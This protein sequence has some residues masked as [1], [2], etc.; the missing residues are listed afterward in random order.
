MED[1]SVKIPGGKY[2][3]SAGSREEAIDKALGIYTM[4]LNELVDTRDIYRIPDICKMANDGKTFHGDDTV[5]L[6]KGRKLKKR[7]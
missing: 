1:F 7:R 3:I 6:T 2:K 4:A 5:Y